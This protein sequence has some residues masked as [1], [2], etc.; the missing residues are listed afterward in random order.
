MVRKNL[1]FL[2]ILPSASVLLTLSALITPPLKKITPIRACLK[3]ADKVFSK[4]L[5]VNNVL[6]I[7]QIEQPLSDLLET[8]NI[9]SYEK[10]ITFD[11]YNN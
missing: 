8:R 9:L 7:T 11:K 4:S 5:T 2:G 6:D 10:I 3:R 1:I